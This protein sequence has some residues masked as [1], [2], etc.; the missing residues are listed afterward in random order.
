VTTMARH[1]A[2]YVGVVRQ[3]CGLPDTFDVGV[4]GGMV[5]GAPGMCDVLRT[6]ILRAFPRARVTIVSGTA[7][8]GVIRA[9]LAE[10]AR[11]PASS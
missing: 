7:L 2:G 4:G 11:L 5:R 6:E 9:A 3:R 1:V 8:E 10:H